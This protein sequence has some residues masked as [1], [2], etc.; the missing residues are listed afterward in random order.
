[1]LSTTR[2]KVHCARGSTEGLSAA[3]KALCP[4]DRPTEEE[5]HQQYKRKIIGV[6]RLR[7]GLDEEAWPVGKERAWCIPG[8]VA[9][10]VEVVLDCRADP[11]PFPKGAQK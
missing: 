6:V 5:L 1:M 7:A 2:P 9:H 8:K 4:T 3:M 11:L 10:P